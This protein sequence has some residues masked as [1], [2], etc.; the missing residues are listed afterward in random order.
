MDKRIIE[1]LPSK[2][3][4]SVEGL[5]NFLGLPP[6]IVQQKLSDLGIG[7]VAFSSR[8]KHKLFRIEDLRNIRKEKRA[9]EE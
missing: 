9:Q 1:I 8:Y 4:W 6:A 5:A 2:G 3:V 7:V